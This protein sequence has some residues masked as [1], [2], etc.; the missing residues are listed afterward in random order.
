LA[1]ILHGILLGDS[2]RDRR[3][4]ENFSINHKSILVGYVTDPPQIIVK[5]E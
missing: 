3:A 5:T 1:E 4:V 2:A